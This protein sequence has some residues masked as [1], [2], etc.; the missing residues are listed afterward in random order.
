ME[1]TLLF[2]VSLYT[3]QLLYREE[4]MSWNDVIFLV[5]IAQNFPT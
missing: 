4:I 1:N 3:T 5:F 2:A